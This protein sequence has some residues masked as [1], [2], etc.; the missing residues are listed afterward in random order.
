MWTDRWE[1]IV[2]LLFTF[3]YLFCIFA[4]YQLT[5]T[6]T[7][8]IIIMNTT[9]SMYTRGLYET[10]VFVFTVLFPTHFWVIH[11]IGNFVNK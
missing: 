9:L 10:S 7:T 11:V 4:L 6:A 3:L 1:D 2:K 5:T 8:I